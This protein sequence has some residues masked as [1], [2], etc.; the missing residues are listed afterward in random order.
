MNNNKQFGLA[1]I[2]LIFGLLLIVAIPLTLN[3]LNQNQNLQNRAA[4]DNCL[5]IGQKNCFQ[6]PCCQGLKCVNSICM[7]SDN[8][9]T[10][11]PTTPVTNAVSCSQLKRL[12][13]Q[14]CQ[15][16]QMPNPSQVP[17]SAIQSLINSNNCLF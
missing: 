16:Y 6:I 7:G 1:T 9:P 5:G 14:Y 10:P 2:P 13:L 3:Q 17:C 4:S 8:L 15:T 12:Y 11:Q